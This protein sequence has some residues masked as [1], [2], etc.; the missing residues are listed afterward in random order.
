MGN[1]MNTL[2]KNNCQIN[3]LGIKTIVYLTPGKFEHLEENPE[4]KCFH[5]ETKEPEKP[6][7][8]LD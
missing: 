3:W 5:F 1:M 4:Y 2:D 7:I 6:L 8:E